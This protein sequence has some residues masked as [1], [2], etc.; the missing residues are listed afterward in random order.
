MPKVSIIIPVYNAQQYLNRCMDSIMNQSY[1]D[2]EVI[3]INDCS[4][5]SSQKILEAYEEKYG[6]KIKLLVNQEN[7]GAA[8]CRGRGMAAAQGEYITFVDS[9]DYIRRDYLE[10]YCRYMEAENV[11]AAIGGYTK[12]VGGKLT[13][14]RIPDSCWSVITYAIA[15][16][17]MYKKSF[18][19]EHGLEFPDIRRGEDI[20]FNMAVY[21][22]DAR[23]VIMDYTGYYYYFNPESTTS[24]MRR[25]KN[26]EQFVA[27]IFDRFLDKHPLAN[28]SKER[29]R[30]I[31]YTYLANMVNAFITYGR[32]VGIGRMKEK[33]SFWMQDMKKRF[34]DYKS[35]PHV[36]IRKPRGQTLKIRLGVGVVMGLQKLH[37]DKLLLYIISLL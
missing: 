8:K 31:E 16:A 3:C 22:H 5:D 33:Y 1:Q 32:G 37:L 9:D 10:T 2:F 21:Y 34:P 29:Q 28:I 17:K 15:C 26:Y 23:Y 36:G 24:T 18:L 14:H 35:N 25:E 19:Q 6:K 7:I 13:E 30:V 12:D 4:P 27:E 11:D 20:Y